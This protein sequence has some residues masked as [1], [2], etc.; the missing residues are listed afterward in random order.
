MQPDMRAFLNTLEQNGRLVRLPRPVNP[1]AE[2]AALIFEAQKHHQAVLFEKVA[3]S[4]MPV[5]ANLVGD[6]V[7]L[8]LALGVQPNEAV[9]TFL[10][11]SRQRIPPMIVDDAPVQ[12][13]VRL[14]NGVD[15]RRLPLV[16]H[17][18]KDAGPYITAGLVIVKDPQSGIRNVSYNR[19]MLR[20]PDE[21][22]IRLMPPQQLG[23]IYELA[24]ASG[25]SLEAAVAIGNHP[26]ELIAGA[27]TLARGDDELALAGALRGEPLQLVKCKTVDLEVPG[28]AEIILEGEILA[29]MTTPEGPFGDFMQFYVPIMDNR[30]FRV[31]A[32]THRSAPI[33]QTM[34]AGAAEDTTLLAIS[35]EAQIYEAVAAMGADVREV[36]LVPTILAGVISI[37]KRYE[38]EPKLVMAAAFGRYAWLKVCVVV[39]EDVNVL[40][41][42]DVWWAIAARSRLQQGILH[43]TDAAGLS[44]DPFGFHSAKLGV[45]ATIP[46]NTWKEH[47]RKRA[48]GQGRVRL[49]DFM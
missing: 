8:A 12:E 1:R 11:R 46:L 47:E 3:G 19:M 41:V 7:M 24:N 20:G 2:L 32:I 38:G 42:D 16:I 29:N 14:G 30:V 43:I 36:S 27:T 49:E 17:S 22:G 5:A 35:R 44:R 28:N 18:E 6:R 15:L 33:Y 37:H 40:N 26:A 34:H 9:S 10:E 39:D 45:D 21:T 25:H 13:V 48:P 4:T 31:K 23:Q